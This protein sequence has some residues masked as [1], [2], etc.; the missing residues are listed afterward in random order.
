MGFVF[1]SFSCETLVFTKGSLQLFLPYS[2]L[3]HSF[4]LWLRSPPYLTLHIPPYTS[5]QPY[6]SDLTVLDSP[7]YFL[8]YK[9]KLIRNR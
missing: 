6:K 3:P 4:F 5:S 8:K 2:Q 9:C 7:D 1:Q